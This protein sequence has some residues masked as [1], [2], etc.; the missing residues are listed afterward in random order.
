MGPNRSAQPPPTQGRSPSEREEVSPVAWGCFFLFA[1]AFILGGL[2]PVLALL[3]VFPREEYFGD[4]P[5]LIIVVASLGFF[6]MGV[7]LLIVFIR[8]LAGLP[9]PSGRIF[10]DLIVFSLA[11][12]FHYWLFFV[13]DAQA[14]SGLTLPGGITIF[15]SLNLPLIRLILGK[16]VVAL[17]C[18]ILD[19]FLISE[20]FGLGWFRRASAWGTRE[21]IEDEEGWEP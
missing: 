13:W 9:P 1:L 6:F 19:L 21:P 5:A 8:A 20:I 15:T 3:G 2:L 14:I 16:I 4:Q 11:V 7:Y 10:A 18:L 17:V 12:P